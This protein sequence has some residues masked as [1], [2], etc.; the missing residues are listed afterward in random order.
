MSRL[1]IFA[2][3]VT[4]AHVG[5]PIALS[6][7]L[8]RLGH[9]VCI[10]ASEAADR[11]L[12]AESVPRQRIVSMDSDRFLRA[13]ARGSPAYDS[14]TLK[15][16]VEDDLAAI[17]EW[18]P[19]AVLG[20]FRLSLYISARLARKPYGAIANAYWSRR[21][22]PG[23]DAPPVASLSWLPEF[24]A[25][26]VFRLAYPL[27]FAVHGS[28]FRRACRYYGVTPPGVDIRD[29]YTASDATAFAD[30]GAFYEASGDEGEATFIGPLAWEP[31]GLH[32]P[33][34]VADG[35]PVVFV[36][37]GSSGRASDWTRLLQALRHVRARLIVATSGQGKGIDGLPRCIHQAEYVSYAQASAAA[38]LVVCN[39]GAPATYA[40]LRAGR[41]V[42]GMPA[43]LDQL[44]NLR[45]VA[46]LHAGARLR[47]ADPA[48]MARVIEA[49]LTDERLACGARDAARLIAEAEATPDPVERWLAR[50]AAP[51]EPSD[52][53]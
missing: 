52:R 49:A 30:V 4:L 24:G 19:D 10:A 35:A 50:L 8:R 26:A 27:A 32:E 17:E 22:W 5:R 6:R 39:G 25:N 41:P 15:R 29:V 23:V 12:E 21:Y 47:P 1:L 45:V 36:S 14:D 34:H 40:A 43:N 31:P 53:H 48:S 9:D 38:T 44:L 3:A 18:R 42:L 51:R 13:L 20:D 16:Y 11:W 28:S 37:V 46:R 2:E 33:L 7:V